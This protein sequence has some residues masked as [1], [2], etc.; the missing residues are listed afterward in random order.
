VSREAS[1]DAGEL[2]RA[3]DVYKENADPRIIRNLERLLHDQPERNFELPMYHRV[4]DLHVNPH[5]WRTGFLVVREYEPPWDLQ[6]AMHESTPQALL[7]D[8]YRPQYE[9][10][11]HE[12]EVLFWFDYG[13]REGMKEARAA[14][15][16]PARPAAE[17]G[18][19]VMGE[20]LEH[21]RGLFRNRWEPLLR[22]DEERRRVQV[23]HDPSRE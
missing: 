21:R 6:S 9:L 20:L 12:R 14:Q 5:A 18:N 11:W 13:G 17:P 8:L 3:R 2:P 23:Y 7:R 22:D 1:R 19:V 15:Q 4:P 10:R 16:R